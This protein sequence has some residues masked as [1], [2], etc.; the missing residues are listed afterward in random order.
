MI[1]FVVL[2][3]LFAV[4]CQ[5]AVASEQMD[6]ILTPTAVVIATATPHSGHA[7]AH[8]DDFDEQIAEWMHE[9]C[10]PIIYKDKGYCWLVR[11]P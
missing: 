8:D 5:P 2:L 3:M 9:N 11:Y 6:H 10:V 7:H 1:R 4:A